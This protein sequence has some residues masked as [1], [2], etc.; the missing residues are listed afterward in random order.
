MYEDKAGTLQRIKQTITE[1][2]PSNVRDRLVLENDEVCRTLQ[3][4]HQLSL[5]CTRI[6][7][8]A[9]RLKTFSHYAKSSACL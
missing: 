8:Y 4:Y 2:I 6:C 5:T 1:V 9:I 7:S 3:S